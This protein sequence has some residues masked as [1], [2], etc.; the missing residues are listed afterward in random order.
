MQRL[1]VAL[2]GETHAG[3]PVA[4]LER[5]ERAVMIPVRSTAVDNWIVDET[6]RALAYMVEILQ[7]GKLELKVCI[8]DAPRVDFMNDPRPLLDTE[9]VIDLTST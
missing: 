5:R 1:I 2:G 9:P 7:P 8:Y 4:S 3:G 6:G